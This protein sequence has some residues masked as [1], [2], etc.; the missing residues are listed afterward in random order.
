MLNSGA[1]GAGTTA[2]GGRRLLLFPV[3]GC[4]MRH[5]CLEYCPPR[6]QKLCQCSP[7]LRSLVPPKASRFQ[8]PKTLVLFRVGSQSLA[9]NKIQFCR[10]NFP[11]VFFQNELHRLWDILLSWD[12]SLLIVLDCLPSIPWKGRL[13]CHGLHFSPWTSFQPPELS[14]R[15]LGFISAPR[16]VQP[17]VVTST[18]TS[19]LFKGAIC[20][21]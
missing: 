15:P 5:E 10:F 3:S 7:A 19:Y 18:T 11:D 16:K 4:R 21:D 12:T 20:D 9:R 2:K 1:E 8:G 6:T 13:A 17:S 14:F